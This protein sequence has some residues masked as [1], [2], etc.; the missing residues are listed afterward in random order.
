MLHTFNFD[1]KYYMFDN[2]SSTLLECDEKVH[3]FLK[4][5]LEK[6]SSDE[7]AEITSE[8]EE[9]KNSGLILKE[10]SKVVPP[11]SEH[12][13]ALCLHICHDC[14]LRCEY[15]FASEG[16]FKGEREYM[17]E[18]VGLK[19]VDFLIANSGNRKILEMDFF[20]GEPLMNLDVV[21]KVVEYDDD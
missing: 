4:G 21:K 18:E 15:C 12:V 1:D 16:T 20:G 7:L 6:L 9:L 11:K 2:V 17:S 13:K 5:E 3:L 19:A 8:I 10:E 14:N